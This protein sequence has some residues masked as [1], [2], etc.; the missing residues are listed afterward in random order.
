MKIVLTEPALADLEAVR[1]HTAMNYPQHVSK[2][3]RRFRQI[4]ARVADMPAGFPSAVNF[5]DVRVALMRP[6]PYKILYRSRAGILQILRII[7][8]A[9]SDF[10][11]D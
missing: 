8:S 4:V 9:R 3:V 1:R 6:Y 11:L 5:P 2:I 7:H 10:K